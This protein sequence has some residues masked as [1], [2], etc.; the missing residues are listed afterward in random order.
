MS[1]KE[2]QTPD[3][4]PAADVMAELERQAAARKAAGP[5]CPVCGAPGPVPGLCE[6]CYQVHNDDPV[7][8][9]RLE[10][11]ER[12][13]DIYRL[14][15]LLAYE[16][17]TLDRYDNKAAIESCSGYPDVNLYIHGPAG[18]GKTHLAT[19]IIRSYPGAAVL[20]PQYINRIVREKT[21]ISVAAEQAI[22]ERIVRRRNLVID[23]LGADKR[24]EYSGSVLYEVLDGRVMAR[25]TGLIVTSNL[26]LGALAER[27]QD[28]RIPSR[29]AGLCRVVEIKGEDRRISKR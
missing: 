19:A 2:N 8:K 4:I 22:I 28:D 23:D 21:K 29:L 12:A 11:E 17:F 5:R 18:T 6:A 13:R 10:A 26:S 25:M 9:A 14:G 3:M 16:S 15:G 20:K 1:L 7:G 24:T 27:L